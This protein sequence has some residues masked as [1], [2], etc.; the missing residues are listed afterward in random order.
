MLSPTK[1]NRFRALWCALLLLAAHCVE[2]P[3]GNNGKTPDD[4]TPVAGCDVGNGGITLPPGFC[5]TIFADSLSYPRHIAVSSSGDVYTLLGGGGIVALRDTNQDGHA[6]IQQT[7]GENGNTGIVVHEH[8]LYVDEGWMIVRYG[9]TPGSLLPSSGPEIV[10]KGMPTE[11]AHVSRAMAVDGSGNLF[12]GIGSST[13]VCDGL[14]PHDPCA[15][16]ALHAGIWRFDANATD[17]DFSTDARFATGIR[18]SVGLAIHPVTHLL[19]A[20]QHGRDHLQYYP[21]MFSTLDAADNPAEEL[22]QVNQ[23]DDFGW[24]Y[25]YYDRRAG[26]HVLMPE[27]GG[28]RS[29]VGRCAATKAP[30]TAFPGHWAPDGLVFYSGALFPAR[31]RN[32]AF[33]SFHGSWNRAPQPQSGYL[34]AFVPAESSTLSSSYEVFADGFSGADVLLDNSDAAHR[35]VG[36][37]EDSA[38]ALYITDDLHGRIWRVIYHGR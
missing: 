29:A 38:G 19:Y 32:G 22:F 7:F 13:N 34:V 9:L 18:N 24:P 6:D 2:S 10:V 33:V 3:S 37:A 25:C 12:I 30:V 28:N 26:R 5:A 1:S 36:L 14:V 11:G 35:P 23:G 16:L 8:S 17:Q 20:T 21:T 4:G 31:Y 15:D 27:Y